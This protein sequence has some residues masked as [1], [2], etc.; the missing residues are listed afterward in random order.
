MWKQDNPEHQNLCFEFQG[1]RNDV[2][3]T[4]MLE[5][6]LYVFSYQYRAEDDWP[7]FNIEIENVEDENEI[8]RL[9]DS[10]QGSQA[11][12]ILK[13]KQKARILGGKYIVS[14]SVDGSS[15]WLIQIFKT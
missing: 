5:K 10:Q 4:V 1:N 2:S 11:G 13:G 8:I 14:I 15:S 9:E 3:D 7:M 12:I 6:G